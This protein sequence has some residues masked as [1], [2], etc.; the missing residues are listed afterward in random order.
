MTFNY[1]FSHLLVIPNSGAVIG[2]KIPPF[3]TKENSKHLQVSVVDV[4]G[5]N[6]FDVGFVDSF[7]RKEKGQVDRGGDCFQITNAGTAIGLGDIR[8]CRT[9]HGEGHYDEIKAFLPKGAKVGF[10]KIRK[11]PSIKWYVSVDCC[12]TCQ[13]CTHKCVNS[14]FDCD[15]TVWPTVS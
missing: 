12:K 7:S 3:R 4:D 14:S 10:Q 8:D 1:A 6:F 11:Q 2:Y 9:T 13:K 15:Y 5:V